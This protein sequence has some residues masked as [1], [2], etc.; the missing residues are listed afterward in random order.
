MKDIRQSLLDCCGKIQPQELFPTLVPEAANL[1]ADDP[2]AFLLA[3]SLDRGMKAE[4]IWTIPFWMK[5]ALGHLDPCL[6]SA[7]DLEH[8]RQTVE[9]LP[10]KP[11]YTKDAPQTIRAVSRLVCD[12]CAGDT[13][14]LWQ[15]KSAAEVKRTLLGIPG[16]GDGIASMALIL[17]E[18]CRRIR[19]PDWSVMDVKPDVHVQRVLCRLGVS[20]AL[21]EKEAIAA[22]QQLNPDYPG[23]MDPPLWIIGRRWCKAKDPDCRS[24]WINHVCPRVGVV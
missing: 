17:L 14:R 16:V 9:A 6:L 4:I 21:G 18:R 5:T 15:D 11:R 2:F 19:F 10:R 8:I 12:G 23:A 24:C 20:N 22:A 13:T 3:V 7:M 1:I